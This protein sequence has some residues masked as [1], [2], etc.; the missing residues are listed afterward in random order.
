MIT[1]KQV[2][3]AVRN[4]REIEQDGYKI[5]LLE[6]VLP[7][8]IHSSVLVSKDEPNSYMLFLCPADPL[9]QVLEWAFKEISR[10]AFETNTLHSANNCMQ[11]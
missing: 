5:C 3:D 8:D 7:T 4:T 9:N 6:N 11:S 10:G 1:G 2:C